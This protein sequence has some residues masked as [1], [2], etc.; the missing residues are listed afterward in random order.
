MLTGMKGFAAPLDPTGAASLYGPPPWRFAGRSITVLA[1]CDPTAVAALVPAPLRPWGDP[2]VRFSVHELTCDLGFGWDYAQK[3]PQRCRLHE[4]VVGIAVEHQGRI[5]HW[6]PFLWTDSDAELAVGR[7]MYGWPQRLGAMAMTAPHPL[8]GFRAG[9]HAAARV[10]TRTDPVLRL[11]LRIE[12]TGDLDVPQPPFVGFF[13]ERVLP[14]P[15][16]GATVRELHFS[17]MEDVAVADLWSGPAMLEVLAPELL[18]LRPGQPLGGKVNA[19]S[20]VK[21]HATLVA[22]SG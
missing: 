4:C 19:V 18:P 13:T 12:R 8:H 7:E 1:P 10:A 11:G 21:R 3:N 17:I 16:G 9:D 15:T 2:V 20:W 5:G 6:D 14:D 22:R